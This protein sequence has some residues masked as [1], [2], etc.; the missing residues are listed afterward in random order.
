MAYIRPVK[1]PNSQ[2]FCFPFPPDINPP[3]NRAM[4]EMAVIT[5]CTEDSCRDVNLRII[6]N[7]KLQT[8]AKVNIAIIPYNID[9]PKAFDSSM[10]NLPFPYEN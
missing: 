3:V 9:V 6:A 7:R 8:M 10:L 5:Y 2:P 4:N 1:P